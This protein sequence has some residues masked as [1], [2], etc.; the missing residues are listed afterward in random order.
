MN[1]VGSVLS[2]RTVRGENEVR[3]WQQSAP[4]DGRLWRWEARGRNGGRKD[5]RKVAEQ[6]SLEGRERRLKYYSSASTVSYRKLKMLASLWPHR[7]RALLS[8][9]LTYLWSRLKM[10]VSHTTTLVYPLRHSTSPSPIAHAFVQATNR[11][12]LLLVRLSSFIFHLAFVFRL[13]SFPF[14]FPL[15]PFGLHFSISFPAHDADMLI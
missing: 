3:K 7:S 4:G 15:S 8:R 5:E 11:R 9:H 10:A 13:S 2:G 1:L 14:G 6:D 12:L